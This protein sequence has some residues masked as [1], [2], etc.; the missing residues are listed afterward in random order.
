MAHQ[1]SLPD[2]ICACFPLLQDCLW[3]RFIPIAVKI[4]PARSVSALLGRSS[5]FQQL[6]H[7]ESIPSSL[8]QLLQ[9]LDKI[10]SCLTDSRATLPLNKCESFMY[11]SA[12]LPPRRSSHTEPCALVQCFLFMADCLNSAAE[13]CVALLV[14]RDR[15][16]RAAKV[17]CHFDDFIPFDS[18][19]FKAA[20]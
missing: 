16:Q 18:Q 12:L 17:M 10:R 19:L 3:F 9:S 4:I 8:S 2:G 14:Q 7:K 11:M 1:A 20:A 15:S 13:T 6:G 5:L